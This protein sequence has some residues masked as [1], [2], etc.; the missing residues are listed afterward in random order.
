MIKYP[1]DC[2]GILDFD[3]IYNFCGK[4]IR[5]MVIL[6]YK[7][8][9]KTIGKPLDRLRVLDFVKRRIVFKC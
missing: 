6:E 3:Y 4:I 9:T 7:Y 8:K 1:A 5:I 2:C